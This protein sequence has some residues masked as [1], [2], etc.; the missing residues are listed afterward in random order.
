MTIAMIR[1]QDI[2]HRAARGLE[3]AEG[4]GGS[5]FEVLRTSKPLLALVLWLVSRP[6]TA[7]ACGT[8]PATLASAALPD[9]SATT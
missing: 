7:Q 1:P 9:R 3:Q 2:D 6:V 8:G 4:E 5:A